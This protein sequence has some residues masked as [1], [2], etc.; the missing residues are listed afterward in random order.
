M[1]N[2]VD[3]S[4]LIPAETCDGS[5]G[6]ASSTKLSVNGSQLRID[7]DKDNDNQFLRHRLGGSDASYDDD[8]ENENQENLGPTFSLTMGVLSA[9]SRQLFLLKFG[10]NLGKQVDKYESA[11][12]STNSG[13]KEGGGDTFLSL[14]MTMQCAT[15]LGPRSPLLAQIDSNGILSWKVQRHNTIDSMGN[16]MSSTPVVSG[17]GAGTGSSAPSTPRSLA[18]TKK[19]KGPVDLP[20]TFHSRVKSSGYGQEPKN[21]LDRMQRERQKR[22]R[23]T[24]SSSAP[25]QDVSKAKGTR[26]RQYPMQCGLIT[27]FQ[28]HNSLPFVQSTTAAGAGGKMRPTSPAVTGLVFSSDASTIGVISNDSSANT[29]RLPV[30]RHTGSSCCYIGHNGL[31]KS[32]SFSLN[33]RDPLVL[34]SSSDG[35]ARIWRQGLTDCAAVVIDHSSHPPSSSLIKGH[36]L[37]TTRSSLASVSATSS[38][39]SSPRNRIISNEIISS[40][41]F[42]QDQLICMVCRIYYIIIIFLY[43]I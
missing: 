16:T 28:P 8:D 13:M 5:L 6:A 17:K 37:S 11:G 14:V 34:T 21:I 33:R 19:S 7:I 38:S 41:F 12:S 2:L 15:A 35:S 29:F 25:T 39:S 22:L 36:N 23:A 31:V 20:V 30:A 4:E 1:N 10:L 40:S 43:L 26:I 42:N 32:M 27:R 18:S 9:F 3:I 24:R